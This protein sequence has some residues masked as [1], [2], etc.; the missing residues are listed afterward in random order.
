MLG[1]LLLGLRFIFY[2]A[3]GQRGG[4]IQSLILAAVLLITGFHTMLIGLLADLTAVNRRLSEEM[5]IRLKRMEMPAAQPKQQQQQQ[6]RSE[7]PP[8]R[9]AAAAK[10]AAPA[11]PQWVWLL[12]EDKLQ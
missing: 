7:R 9:E 1:G 3:E 8:R 11:E 4:H 5:L 6:P 2:F 10:P 12:D